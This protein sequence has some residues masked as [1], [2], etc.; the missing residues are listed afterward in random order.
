MKVVIDLDQHQ[1]I[2]DFTIRSPAGT[3]QFK[4]Q[5]TVEWEL[6]FVQGGFVIDMGSSFALKFGMIKTGDPT[7]TLLAY[8]TAFTYK[9]DSD[10]NVYYS[11]LVNFNTS[12]MA[13][14]IGTSPSMAGTAEIR[15]QD[16]LN[17]IIHTINISTMVYATILVE[18]GT[19]P[20]SVPP[21]Y[22]DASTLELL[23]HKDQPSGYAGLNSSG[24]LNGAD[25][26]VDTQTVVIN[27]SGQIA[28]AAILA[29]VAANFTTPAANATVSV[30]LSSTTN[31]RTNAYVRIPIAGYYV[32]SSITDTTHAV[33]QNNGDPFNA[34]SGVTITTGAVLLPAQAA[35][36]GGGGAG[37]NAYTTLS[38]NFT[39]PAVG[40]TVPIVVGSTAWM[41]GSGYGIYISGAGYYIVSSITDA[42]HAVVTNSGTG[43]NAPPATVVT[44][45]GTISAAG[46]MGPAGSS[47]TTLAS[48]DALTLPFTMPAASASVNISIAN[49][50]WL[51]LSQVIYIASAGYFQVGSIINATNASITNLNYPGN[52]SAGTSISSGSHVGPAGPIGPQGTGGAGLNAFT[53]LT[54]SFVQPAVGSS[55]TATVGSTSWI[56]PNEIIFVQGGGYYQVTSIPDLTHVSLSNLGYTGN[57]APGATVTGGTGVMVTPGGLAGQGGNSFTTTT[58]SFTQPAT[59]SNVTATFA[60]TTWMVQNQYVFVNGGG[61]Y[62]VVNI[63]DSTHAVL[64][65]I[66]TT[67]NALSGA[68]IASGTGVSPAGPPGPQGAT[69]ATGGIS[70]APSDGTTYGR[71]NAAWTPVF[72]GGGGGAGGY[73][74]PASGLY[75][76]DDFMY[77]TGLPS[78]T[79]YQTSLGTGATG[80]ANSAYGQDNVKKVLGCYELATGTNASNTGIGLMWGGNAVGY[81]PIVYGISGANLVFKT[82]IFLQSTLPATGG[83]YA[84]RIGFGQQSGTMYF[85]TPAQAFYFEY[86]PDLNSGLWRVGVGGAAPA[87][88]NTSL[89]VAG[90]TSYDLEIDVNSAW[91]S[92]NFLINGTVAATVTTGIPTTTAGTVFWQYAKGSAGATNQKAAI[93]S[94]MIYYPVTR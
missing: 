76:A 32:V 89:A 67:G 12:Q 3:Y 94:W 65:N 1:A 92:I 80:N 4:S 72:G 69:G 77:G 48:Y 38:A 93:D 14:A 49:T 58:A 26:P 83:G 13:T 2:Q 51:G 70:D 20:P 45:G 78:S 8:N 25:I 61:T 39:V 88:T 54:T 28:S 36:G 53:T 9:T 42:T 60:N 68:V 35:A 10:G 17:E 85:N 21:T 6:Y 66:G 50:A 81:N 33:L 18:S 31:L 37:Q 57:A 84:L 87:Y 16:A 44:S 19:T 47:G 63:N 43:A 79:A 15:Y 90:D 5:D 64:Q 82:R 22:P 34:A 73:W 40:A 24:K 75:F 56:A 55:V 11:G 46:P 59:G 41:G 27:G 7:N 52:A 74:D 86:S 23:V 62:Q 71:K 30:T 91:N 29:S